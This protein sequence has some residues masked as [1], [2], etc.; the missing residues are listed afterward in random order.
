MKQANIKFTYH[1]YLQ[2]PDNKRYELVEGE[3]YLVPSPNLYHQS[4]SREIVA[5]LYQH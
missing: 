5:V 1:D 3:L 4:I 2:L